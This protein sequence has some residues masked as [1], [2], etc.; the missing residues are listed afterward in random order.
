[1]PP[2][3]ATLPQAATR[4]STLQSVRLCGWGGGDRVDSQLV[5]P[6]RLE[7]LTAALALLRG[8]GAIPRGMGRSYGD[9]AQL[10]GGLVLDT[11]NLKGF[12]LDAQRGAV[13]ASAGVPLAELLARLVPAGWTLPVLPGTQHVSVG[14]AIASDIHGK[15]HAADGTF[16]A[17]VEELA[18][19]T[20]AG[21]RRRLSPEQD[22][23]A[24]TL[25][26]M[27]LTGVI[28]SARLRLRRVSSA[29]LSVDCDRVDDLDQ[30]LAALDAPGGRYRVAWLDLLG[31]R[32][33]RGVVTR[34]DHLPA[35]AAAGNRPGRATA[36][37][38]ATVP[39][40]WPGWVLRPATVRA[41]NELR[42]RRTPRR[43]RGYVESIAQHMFPLDVL[44]R[45]PRLYGAAGF[46]QYQ[47]VVPRGAER[48]LQAAIDTLRSA[49]IPCYLAVLKDFGEPNGAQLSFPI[50]GWTLALD[51]PRSAP[52]LRAVLDDLDDGVAAAGGRVYLSKDSR[53]RPEALA[54][55]YPR[56]DE[57]RAIRDRLDPERVWRSDLATRTRLV[58]G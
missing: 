19:L 52:G 46:L 21:E 41:Y 12:D 38:R 4:Q 8:R 45:W 31:S 32:T 18:L 36:P 11:T 5:R 54:A 3:D 37:A 42:F 16:G 47:L 44:N 27:G 57:W 6:E 39:R 56:L 15:G 48:V 58:A 25:G 17:H 10:A 9:A 34:A 51:I 28:V 13:T 1:M 29:L 55:M 40:W 22:E 2:A 53:M 23:F 24:A 30:A 26:G 33:G 49:R 43:R 7:E 50:K 14:G 35:E 20:A